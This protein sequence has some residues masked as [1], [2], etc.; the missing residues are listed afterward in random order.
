MEQQN[1][2]CI[3]EKLSH[4]QGELIA[5]KN[6]HNDYGNYWYRNAESIF[7]SAKPICMKYR[8]TLILEDYIEVVGDRYYVKAV[9]TLVDW[10]SVEQIQVSAY[11]RE[12]DAK[13]GMDGS[14]ITGSCSSYARKYAMN[15]LF[16]ID[17]VKDADSNEQKEEAENK[18]A[19]IKPEPK[20]K[21]KAS[22]KQIDY[23]AKLYTDQQ[24]LEMVKRMGYQSIM[25]ISQE[26]ASKMIN[27]RKGNK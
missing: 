18:E 1:N 5:P 4:I 24:I 11:A 9:A 20:P 13:K 3:Y 8:T 22:Q 12:D 16:N 27:A 19:G 10:D 2:M 7:E 15:G 14:Q 23:I 21:Q 6:K 26:E 25:D 17:D